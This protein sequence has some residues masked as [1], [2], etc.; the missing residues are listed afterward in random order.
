MPAKSA[1]TDHRRLPRR[2]GQVLIEA[3]HSATLAELAE[4][5]YAQLTIDR[6]AKRACTSKAAIYRRW[7][8]RADLVGAAINFALAHDQEL[9]PDT[10]DLRTDLFALLRA[11]ADRLATSFGEAARW[12]LTE[13]LIDP[14]AT[15][16]VREHVTGTRSKLIETVVERAVRRGQARTEALTPQLISLAPALL[17]HHFLLQG[18]PIDDVVIDTILD[19][20]VMPLLRP[21]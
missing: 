21:R 12:L 15:R 14:E 2:R 17:I 7:P 8:S 20:I 4:V 16:A 18:T 13:T 3:I 10:G 5:G 11:A 1:A 9:A 6:V 19:D